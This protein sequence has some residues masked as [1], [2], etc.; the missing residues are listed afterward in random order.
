LHLRT[1]LRR[2]RVSRLESHPR[3]NRAP[4]LFFESLGRFNAIEAT[5]AGGFDFGHRSIG[6]SHARVECECF[7]L[8]TILLVL[9]ALACQPDLDWHI[10]EHCHIWLEPGGGEGYDRV[11][12]TFV[13]TSS[14]ALIRQGRIG[15]AITDHDISADERWLD[16]RID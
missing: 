12:V 8:E 3:G 1:A 6:V 2:R 5:P 15:E 7:G 16:D 14:G 9:R 11:Q 13:K 4:D 10:Q